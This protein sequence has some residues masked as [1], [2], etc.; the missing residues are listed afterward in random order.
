MFK[1][2]INYHEFVYLCTWALS[3]LITIIHKCIDMEVNLTNICGLKISL[4]HQR[5][6]NP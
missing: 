4:M 6:I 3:I 1:I 5:D 2:P